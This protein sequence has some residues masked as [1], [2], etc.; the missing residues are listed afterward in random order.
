MLVIGGTGF[1]GSWLVARAPE[2]WTARAAGRSAGRGPHD[3]RVDVTD[4]ASVRVAIRD[5]R[6]D[7]VV[8]T[9]A[10]AD[11]DRCQR[12]P[13]LAE[14]VNVTGAMNVAQACRDAEC[15]IIYLSSDAVFDGSR[16]GF[17]ETDVPCPL[18]EYGRS[19]AEAERRTRE[20]LP[21]TVVVRPSL[22][23]GRCELPGNNSYLEKL[24]RSFAAGITVP[25]PT[26]E[27]RNPID[28]ATLCDLVWEVAARPEFD[29]ATFHAGSTDRMS[30]DEIARRI[31]TGL[32]FSADC[33]VPVKEAPADRAPRAADNLLRIDAT[34]HKLRTR[35]PSAAGA[36][37]RALSIAP[38]RA[39]G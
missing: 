29:V 16:L 28:A 17:S 5:V 26:Y 19:K 2:S 24:R 23:L 11:I 32:G 27:F 12:E 4:A 18:N 22:V 9:A 34:Q 7:I 6:P 3:L 1:V 13:M 14:A 36:I 37:E 25:S 31:A 39:A 8:L 20:I 30:R 21:A 15:R 38:P 10:L 33:V 35:L